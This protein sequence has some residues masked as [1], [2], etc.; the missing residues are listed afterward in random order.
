MTAMNQ[1][2]LAISDMQRD[3]SKLV[4]SIE[5][6]I[7]REGFH[8]DHDLKHLLS[9]PGSVQSDMMVL[10]TIK[11]A[12]KLLAPSKQ[13]CFEFSGSAF[14]FARWRESVITTLLGQS[15][16]SAVVRVAFEPPR[17]ADDHIFANMK[18]RAFA[19][20][21]SCMV[22][23]KVAHDARDEATKVVA[24]PATDGGMS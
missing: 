11:T 6:S 17:R 19:L 14:D 12:T 16:L 5:F 23:T 13:V 24:E 4:R 8:V 20:P 21:V 22:V 3:A 7:E 2:E 18:Q 9:I 1:I 15:K 10:Y